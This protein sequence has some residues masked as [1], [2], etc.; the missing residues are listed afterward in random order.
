MI[1]RHFS[2]PV[3]RS[4]REQ[5]AG[6]RADVDGVAGDQRRLQ[7]LAVGEA[8]R[9]GVGRDVARDDD[10]AL[11]EHAAAAGEGGRE[12]GG[13]AAQQR[14]G[15]RMVDRAVVAGGVERVRAEQMARVQRARQAGLAGGAAAVRALPRD[16]R[17]VAVVG[18]RAA[19]DRRGVDL[20]GVERE[21]HRAALPA[22]LLLAHERAGRRVVDREPGAAAHVDAPA[23]GHGRR[24]GVRA[25]APQHE[26]GGGVEGDRHAVAV[27]REDAAVVIAGGDGLLARPRWTTGA[28]RCAGRARAASPCR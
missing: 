27:G 11:D 13:H 26:A 21:H 28:R 16:P 23:V 19:A 25:A 14:P 4:S 12:A 8:P 7:Q 20:V 9:L 5:D 6:A 3:A 18:D 2:A 1:V 24:L 22:A 17:P 10:A 15:R